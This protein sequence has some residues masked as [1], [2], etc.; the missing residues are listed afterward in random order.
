MPMATCHTGQRLG[1]VH[2]RQVPV[3]AGRWALWADADALERLRPRRAYQR[4]WPAPRS[5]PALTTPKRRDMTPQRAGRSGSRV[6]CAPQRRPDGPQ[7]P[8][9]SCHD[10]EN[11]ER[12]GTHDRRPTGGHH[13]A[14]A[15]TT[16][17]ASHRQLP[18]RRPQRGHLSG[19]GLREQRALHMAGSLP[20][21]GSLVERRAEPKP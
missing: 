13:G 3:A 10:L 20:G 14:R 8:P 16:P 7:Q 4:Q 19:M 11:K 12:S 2:S 1:G 5:P 18:G 9:S 6:R 21:H 17:T 15:R